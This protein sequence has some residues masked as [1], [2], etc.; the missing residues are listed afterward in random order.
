MAGPMNMANS[1][2]CTPESFAVMKWPNSWIK[3][4]KLKIRIAKIMLIIILK[5]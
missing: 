2:T 3:I 4:K 5:Y 1:L